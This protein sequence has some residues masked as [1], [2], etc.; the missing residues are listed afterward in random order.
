MPNARRPSRGY[1]IFM[2]ILVTLL[3]G[4][5]MLFVYGSMHNGVKEPGLPGRGIFAQEAVRHG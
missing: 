1:I 4:S 3:I 5:I 2:V